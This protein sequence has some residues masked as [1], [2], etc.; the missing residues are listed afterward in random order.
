MLTVANIPTPEPGAVCAPKNGVPC[1]PSGT[2]MKFSTK[3]LISQQP[4]LTS[5]SFMI[6]PAGGGTITFSPQ[7]CAVS[8]FIGADSVSILPINTQ[9]CES[10]NK[11]H[12]EEKSWSDSQNFENNSK[13]QTKPKSSK[14]ESSETTSVSAKEKT[15]RISVDS[16]DDIEQK[17]AES[18]E[19]LRAKRW[20]CGRCP[21]EYKDNC[22]FCNTDSKKLKY[23]NSA[24]QLK[25]MIQNHDANAYKTAYDLI[26]SIVY[27]LTDGYSVT[28]T[29]TAHHLI[30][31]NE[32]L[33]KKRVKA[34]TSDAENCN[35]LEYELL[36]KLANFFDY[37]V[38]DYRNGIILPT[39]YNAQ[40]QNGE[41]PEVYFNVMDADVSHMCSV[42]AL[43][44]SSS[45]VG[46]QL[47][48]GPHSFENKL[49]KLKAL[50]PKYAL[51]TTYERIV[52]LY[53]NKLQ[54]YYLNSYSTCCFMKDKERYAQD[55]ILRINDISERLRKN[56]CEFPSQV[57][58]LH[59][60]NKAY[61][62][63][64]AMVYDMRIPLNV[65]REM[66]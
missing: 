29:D 41:E 48:L 56:I 4:A 51:L 14:N 43:G 7:T 15:N 12:S 57:P 60:Q 1:T 40:L 49:G 17:K 23:Q 38:N 65:Y 45:L 19:S 35:A 36:I 30:P 6:C 8:D 11:P 31:G 13:E 2:W 34:S 32:C 64:A 25:D 59:I 50:H 47:H 46:S 5:D 9:P 22:P 58:I 63:F 27:K 37:N 62:S 10:S 28:S 21:D 3:V 66:L 33:S 54:D 16:S 55:F 42:V 61:V 18:P 24:S 26:H 44:K 39:Y 53:L 20:C 52:L